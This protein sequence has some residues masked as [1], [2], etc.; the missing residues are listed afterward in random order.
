MISNSEEHDCWCD[1]I[2]GSDAAFRMLYDIYV[3]KLFSF[4][5]GF[6]RDEETVKDTI[7]D[8]FIDLYRYRAN[9]ARTVNLSAYLY[10][11]MRRKL[12][13]ALKNIR[14]QQSVQL[15]DMD[16]QVD[17]NI[18][19]HIMRDEQEKELVYI[20]SQEIQKLS[21]RQREVLYLRFTLDMTYEEVAEVMDV[22]VATSRTLVYRA[23]KQMRVNM[24]RTNI[25][26]VNLL[27][28]VLSAGS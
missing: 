16:F 20:L 22:S 18:E 13:V 27:M 24:E 17:W 28:L 21:N 15:T 9:V 25:P 7:H 3:D 5:C 19:T 4:G 6:C 12:V 8:L 10:S 1:F 14:K 23:V 26:M 2:A 11:A